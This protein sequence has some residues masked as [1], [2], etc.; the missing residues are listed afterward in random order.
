MIS[1]L[2]LGYALSITFIILGCT[3]DESNRFWNLF[4]LGPH[5]FLPVSAMFINKSGEFE[6]GNPDGFGSQ[7]ACF[8]GAL[9]VVSSISFPFVAWSN[10]LVAN[11]GL[12]YGLSSSL[13]LFSC[14][15]LA[16]FFAVKDTDY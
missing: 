9:M 10:D 15:G 16:A 4:L 12:G 8:M 3:L 11:S 2:G 5:L 7:F 1:L 14:M 6:D 13:T